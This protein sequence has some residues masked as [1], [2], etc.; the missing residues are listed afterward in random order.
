M[1][2]VIPPRRSDRLFFVT[3]ALVIGAFVLIGFWRFY[4]QPGLFFAALPSFLVHVH[5]FLMV[6]WIALLICQVGLISARRV[7]WH[8]RLGAA[9]AFWAAAIV[10]V[11][12]PTAI[13][14]FRRPNSGVDAMILFGDLAQLI[15]F[16]LMFSWA[17]L[18]RRNPAAHKRLM[19]LAT[20][21]MILP[22][23]ARWPFDFMKQGPLGIVLIYFAVP[24]ALAIWDIVTLR[25]I[26]RATV[27]GTA[28]FALV[29]GSTLTVSKTA[30]W[31][32]V[33]DSVQ[34]G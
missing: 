22:A 31:R 34:R 20:A 21:V 27:T 10:I 13:L 18:S 6:G 2:S 14:A 12:P 25:R 19:L 15:G 7:R 3:A 32:A 4:F 8:Q 11:S 23:L 29:L 26:H 28:V 1:A 24:A 30:W 33:T 17:F 16:A 5:A 9:M